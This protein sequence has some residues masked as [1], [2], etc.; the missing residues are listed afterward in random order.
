[1]NLRTVII[2][3][4]L[5]D[6]FIPIAFFLMSGKIDSQ[7]YFF[8]LL[9]IVSFLPIMLRFYK[10]EN[11]IRLGVIFVI[12]LL[13]VFQAILANKAKLA[14]NSLSSFFN[15][16]VMVSFW[17]MILSFT[18]YAIVSLFW[19][20][21]GINSQPNDSV[22][23]SLLLFRGFL[24]FLAQASFFFVITRGEHAALLSWPI[25]NSSP[26]FS[27]LC[28]HLI[29]KEKMSPFEGLS[30]FLF[31]GVVIGWLLT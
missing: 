3:S 31:S 21:N 6:I 27:S 9:V 23:S 19:R 15:F 24:A 26:I 22:S 2:S 14:D 10:N 18:H 13:L 25:L 28:G 29:L 16:F 4:R 20:F 5:S 7:A 17:R 30:F 1:M 12:I 8:S 11:G